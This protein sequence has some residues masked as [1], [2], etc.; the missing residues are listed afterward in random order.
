MKEINKL[1][2]DNIPE[3]IQKNGN[4]C[5]TKILNDDE[6]ILALN[7]K[8]LEEVNEYLMSGEVIELVDIA[9]VIH[10]ILDFKNVSHEQFEKMKF[11]KSEQNGAFKNKVFLQNIE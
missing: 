8:L 11:E 6:Y 10:A 3:I 2:R 1:V 4:K 7:Q 9:E 5:S